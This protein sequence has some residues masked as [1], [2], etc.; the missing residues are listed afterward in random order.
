MSEASETKR[1]QWIRQAVDFGA[2]IAFMAAYFI[3]RDM[4]KATWVLVI[5]SMI[6]LA[7][8]FVL[9]RRLAPMPLITGGFA[10]VFGALTI[11]T[12]DDLFVKLKLTVQNG[13]LAAVLLG[14][15]PLKKS[16]FKALLGSA[17]KVTDAAWRTLTLRYGLYFL[18]VAIANEVF[19]S[20]A[21]VTAIWSALNLGVPDPN[22][23]WTAFRGVLWIAASI[24]GLCQVPL[25]MKNMIKDEEPGP[26]S[27][28]TGL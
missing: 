3:T 12:D 19:R 5:A 16:P 6:A 8:G 27:P 24:F 20:P 15:I 25:I 4:I 14:S 10:L 17:I 9:E 13:L 18:A 22:G 7:V 1:P 11:L 21:A 26:I 23:V 2:L 28:D